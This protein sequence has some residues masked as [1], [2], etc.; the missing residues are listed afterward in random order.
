MS[1][2]IENRIGLGELGMGG[3]HTDFCNDI[4]YDL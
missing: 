2:V 4:R 1:V 3:R